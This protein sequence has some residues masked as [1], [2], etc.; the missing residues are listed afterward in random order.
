VV[1]QV[2]LEAHHIIQL[3][4]LAVAA[5]VQTLKALAAL[6]AYIQEEQAAVVH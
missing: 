2:P 5:E 1:Q 3:C 4:L 6:L